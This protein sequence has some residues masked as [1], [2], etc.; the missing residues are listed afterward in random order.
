MNFLTTIFGPA[1]WPGY[2]VRF[3]LPT[4]ATAFHREP[5]QNVPQDVDAYFG[6]GLLAHEPASGRGTVADVSHVPGAWADLDTKAGVTKE[7]W[8]A[9]LRA[10]DK[11]PTCVVDSGT[12]LHAYWLTN[13]LV[14]LTSEPERARW[15]GVVRALQ[16]HIRDV[17]GHAVDATHDL[18]RVL[19]VPGSVHQ[20]SGNPVVVV[21]DNGPRYDASVLWDL[22]PP[23]R[24]F[25]AATV[26]TV[27]PDAWDAGEIADALTHL[28]AD[29]Y[30]TWI[31]VGMGL[32]CLGE[33]GW[34]L[35]TRW[36]AQSA[37]YDEHDSEKRWAHS[38]DSDG[39][40]TPLTVLNAAR[41]AG[42]QSRADRMAVDLLE[43]WR[44]RDSETYPALSDADLASVVRDH[45]PEDLAYVA[46]AWYLHERGL[47]SECSH[48]LIAADAI[49]ADFARQAARQR[50]AEAAALLTSYAEA[51]AN[52]R[53]AEAALKRAAGRM[54]VEYGTFDVDPMVLL[55]PNG[56]VDLR[57]GEIRE[58]RAADRLTKRSPVVYDAAA[59]APM[60]EQAVLEWCGGN[61]ELASWFQRWCGYCLTGCT[62]EHAFAIWYGP[63][64]GN[65]KSTAL[66]VLRELLGEYAQAASRKLFT[67]RAE[68][69]TTGLAA[70]RGARLVEVA[71]LRAGL[72]L[73]ADRVKSVV[74]ADPQRARFMR[75]DEFE[76]VPAC[77]L[78]MTCNT[79]PPLT[80]IDGGIIRRARVMGWHTRPRYPVADYHRVLLDAE[81]S[82]ILAWCVRGA[83]AWAE[84]GLGDCEAIS[85]ETAQWWASEDTVGRWLRTE[86]SKEGDS[87]FADLYDALL[88]WCAGEG[89]DAD[90]VPSRKAL[91]TRLLREGYERGRVGGA[92]CYHGIRPLDTEVPF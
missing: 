78:V 5:P 67:T 54:A 32:R 89:V 14:P 79:L 80:T 52:N 60:W 91:S 70:L 36:A 8:L 61:V 39:A 77:K 28:D 86:T 40:R 63:K 81:A 9:L 71:E 13:E 49:A 19:R 68:D 51:F 76:F 25:R 73:D 64:A 62:H 35:W 31:L 72:A 24:A 16:D 2:L 38:F 47:W 46:G 34:R 42:W 7:Q 88:T 29:C 44:E 45:Y 83:V 84:Y 21:L 12:G 23:E 69:H 33:T 65:G 18:A 1:P 30:E 75:R 27:D 59:D 37:K 3:D 56:L 82:G 22:C 53:R 6:L 41:E 66:A 17:S 43:R 74:A 11:P 10:L 90:D 50:N 48:P 55:C 87:T 26:A 85:R 15:R 4:Y 92:V 57:T 58:A 20:R